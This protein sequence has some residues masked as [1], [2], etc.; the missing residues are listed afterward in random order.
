MQR[1]ARVAA[2][3]VAVGRPGR[4]DVNLYSL[5]TPRP[6][7]N[8]RRTCVGSD[9]FGPFRLIV[10]ESGLFVVRGEVPRGMVPE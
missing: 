3:A 10:H 4:G 9:D 5:G 7:P 2:V 6:E 8:R 1:V